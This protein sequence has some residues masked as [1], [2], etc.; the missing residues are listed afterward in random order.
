L[1]AYEASHVY[2]F[3]LNTGL[4]SPGQL[5]FSV[6]DGDFTDNSGFYT[7]TVT[8]VP[9]PATWAMMLLGF[10]GLGFTG[11]RATKKSQAAVA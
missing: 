1:P 8:S 2:S 9:E 5:H 4:L 3:E 10:A 6:S 11:Y 7:I